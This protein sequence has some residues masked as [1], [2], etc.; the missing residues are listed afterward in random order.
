MSN[1]TTL[2]MVDDDAAFLRVLSRSMSMLGFNVW[3]S[4][5]IET[6]RQA[7]GAIQPDYAVIDLHIGGDSGIDLLDHIKRSFPDTV[8]VVLSGYVNIPAAV[9]AVRLGAVD[10]LSKPVDPAQLEWALMRADQ[11][12]PPIPDRM[13]Q[14]S[15]AQ[16]QHILAHWE[17][18]DR[19]TSR[20]ARLLGMHRRTL[21][22]ILAR[23]G[24]AREVDGVP[25]PPRRWQKLRR[26]F[27][28]WS[29]GQRL[30]H[31]T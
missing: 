19:N 16:I 21:Q 22:R 13:M 18:N 23:S 30:F 31:S 25:E 9:S 24:M 10:C 20:T 27:A 29:R 8:V 15:E 11:E 3:Q 5:T 7:L 17:K 1:G 28:V 2:L 26:L 4:E 12:R 14:P 6:A